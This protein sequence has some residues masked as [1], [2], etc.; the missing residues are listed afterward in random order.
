MPVA[1]ARKTQA[2]DGSVLLHSLAGLR[3]LFETH[4]I[5]DALGVPAEFLSREQLTQNPVTGLRGYGSHNKAAGTWS[6]DG[7]LMLCSL[8]TLLDDGDYP[9][10]AMPRF[11]A[12]L[13]TGLWTVDGAAFGIGSGTYAALA[14]FASGAAAPWGGIRDQDN[15]NGS[16]MRILP[17]AVA[18]RHL[19]LRRYLQRISEWSSLT[20][21]HPRS[22]TC[23]QIYALVVRGL[24]RGW[25]LRKALR[26][27]ASRILPQLD[28]D[29]R[30]V[31]E[32]LLDASVLTLPRDEIRS[33]CYVVHTLEASLWCL[34]Q[35][36]S[37]ADIVLR[38]VNLGDDADTTAA[39][40]APLAA[41]LH[42]SAALPPAWRNGV[43]RGDPLLA[44]L[45]RLPSATINAPSGLSLQS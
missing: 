6:D 44:L 42:G 3:H 27:A 17:I 33:T 18:L 11:Q 30:E 4:L 9:A 32:R 39:V 37:F 24:L 36:G 21:A 25:P 14:R 10:A 20:H 45:E 7:S 26:E 31:M 12:W 8:E 28:R 29:E 16:L 13:K 41:I 2:A 1:S 5:G 40:T 35:G 15:G 38:A 34:A 22:I 19:P 43:I 23:C